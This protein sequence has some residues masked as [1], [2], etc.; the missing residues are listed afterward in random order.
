M[1]HWLDTKKGERLGFTYT[2]VFS[3]WFDHF[4]VGFNVR[5]GDD[6]RQDKSFSIELIMAIQ[7]FLEEDLLK[8]QSVEAILNVSLHRVF[9]IAGF[10]GRLRGEELPL[11]S[12]RSANLANVCLTLRRRGNGEALEEPCHLAPIAAV[13]VSDCPLAC[14]YIGWWRIM[15]ISVSQMVGCL[16]TRKEKRKGFFK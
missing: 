12:L 5:M 4:I 3:L 15:Q 16:E 13:T 7:K 1:L 6:K 8:Y 11:L 14:G 10:C 9:L 2:S